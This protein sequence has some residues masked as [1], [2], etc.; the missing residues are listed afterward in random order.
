MGY[1]QQE[2]NT[3]THKYRNLTTTKK[4]WK[5]E[6]SN[7]FPRG[8]GTRQWNGQCLGHPS[9]A[10]PRASDRRGTRDFRWPPADATAKDDDGWGDGNGRS[11]TNHHEHDDKNHDHHTE[12]ENKS[13]EHK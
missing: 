12:T 1:K 10:S 6:T 7:G 4:W 11:I 13:I 5:P 3:H 8:V 2:K 9:V